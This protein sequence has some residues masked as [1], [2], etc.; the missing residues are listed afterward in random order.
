MPSRLPVDPRRIVGTGSSP[1]VDYGGLGAYVLTRTSAHRMRLLLNPDA[2]LVG[3]S[4]A[5]GLSAPVAELESRPHLFRLS[6]PGWQAAECR[7]ALGGQP[8]PRTSGGW[9][10]MPG[11]YEI[12]RKAPKS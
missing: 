6:L 3:N 10:L 11:E 8:I 1:W 9:L 7:P 2:R 12:T 4:I 5:G